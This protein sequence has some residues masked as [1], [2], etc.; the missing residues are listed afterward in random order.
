MGSGYALSARVVVV[1]LAAAQLYR[2]IQVVDGRS[3][4]L[5]VDADYDGPVLHSSLRVDCATGVRFYAWNTDSGYDRGCYRMARVT[6]GA[7][8]FLIVR[9]LICLLMLH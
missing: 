7:P 4:F 6:L 3:G 2:S 5:P 9:G 1:V 8:D